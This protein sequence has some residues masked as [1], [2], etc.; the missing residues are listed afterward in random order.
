MLIPSYTPNR[1]PLKIYKTWGKWWICFH[2]VTGEAPR[3]AYPG[4]LLGT[5]LD[6]YDGRQPV[7]DRQAAW[8][9]LIGENGVPTDELTPKINQTSSE[10]LRVLGDCPISANSLQ[11][12]LGILLSAFISHKLL[13]HP[14]YEDTSSWWDEFWCWKSPQVWNEHDCD[15]TFYEYQVRDKE[16]HLS[17]Y[18]PPFFHFQ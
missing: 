1:F 18:L 10:I 4:C 5:C 9:W 14:K 6:L 8:P 17:S 11:C 7:Q 12:Q 3:S 16:W 15:R 2:P 13:G